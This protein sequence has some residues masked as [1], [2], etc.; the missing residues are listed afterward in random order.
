MRDTCRPSAWIGF[1]ERATAVDVRD[2]GAGFDCVDILLRARRRC[3]PAAGTDVVRIGGPR[4]AGDRDDQLFHDFPALLSVTAFRRPQAAGGVFK[5]LAAEAVLVKP[6]FTLNF[7]PIG[8][9]ETGIFATTVRPAGFED[10]HA[11]GFNGFLQLSRATSG[12]MLGLAP[13]RPAAPIWMRFCRCSRLCCSLQKNQSVGGNRYAP[14]VSDVVRR[15]SLQRSG[16]LEC[17]SCERFSKPLDPAHRRL[18]TGRRHRH[19]RPH[20]FRSAEQGAR[21]DGLCRKRRRRQRLY[22]LEHRRNLHA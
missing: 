2:G 9:K 8:K 4:I 21:A 11:A 1:F 16:R 7:F 20:L 15:C 10:R 22:R 19:L 13:K 3:P 17:A 6:D 14:I 5:T 12:A 18:R